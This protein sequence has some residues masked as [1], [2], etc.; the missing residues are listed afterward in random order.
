MVKALRTQ[1]LHDRPLRHETPPSVG[2]IP[3]FVLLRQVEGDVLIA[4]FSRGGLS[5]ENALLV[6]TVASR[7]ARDLPA[8]CFWV[9][10][11][12]GRATPAAIGIKQLR[13]RIHENASFNVRAS[14]A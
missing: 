1:P 8:G 10:A 3:P 12:D 11:Q 2:R 4:P 13:R 5:P 6:K 7:L 14:A 9:D